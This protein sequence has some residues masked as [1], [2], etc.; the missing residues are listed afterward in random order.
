[1]YLRDEERL[2]TREREELARGKRCSAVGRGWGGRAAA[3]GACEDTTAE[4]EAAAKVRKA[5]SRILENNYR[6][7]TVLLRSGFSC[8]CGA[9]LFVVAVAAVVV[10]TG[11]RLS[12]MLGR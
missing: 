8:V 7:H 5:N 6:I 2:E 1:M 4:R 9:F 3:M 12:A 11:L 10:V